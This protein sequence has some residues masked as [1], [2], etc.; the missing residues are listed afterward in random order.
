MPRSTRQSKILDI[1]RAKDIST[2][3]DL[4]NELAVQGY[5]VTQATVSRDIKELGLI[6]ST[7]EHGVYKYVM[8]HNVEQRIPTKLINVFKEAV[9]SFIPVNN[10]LIVKTLAGSAGA[11]ANVVEQIGPAEMLGSVAG[12]DTVLIVT[13]DT[14]AVDS[15]MDKLVGLT[16]M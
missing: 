4:V 5:R 15:L 2:Q 1:I 8:V 14:D 16:R 9:I 12:D 11:V 3:E 13:S 10:L 7:N 6:K